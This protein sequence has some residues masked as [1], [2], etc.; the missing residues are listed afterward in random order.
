MC[1]IMKQKKDF[2][3]KLMKSNKLWSLVNSDGWF[4]SYDK[5]TTVM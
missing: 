3:G 4:L 1:R 5:C 2:K